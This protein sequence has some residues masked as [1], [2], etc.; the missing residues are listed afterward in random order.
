MP[1]IP[2]PSKEIPA[3]MYSAATTSPVDRG[4][5]GIDASSPLPSPL[6][7][8]GGGGSQAAASALS[9]P[10]SSVNTTPSA[11][12]VEVRD[13][14]QGGVNATTNVVMQSDS[15]RLTEGQGGLAKIVAP[16]SLEMSLHIPV[17]LEPSLRSAAVVEE[18]T[19]GLGLVKYHGISPE[20]SVLS[21][22]TSAPAAGS[23]CKYSCA[24]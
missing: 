16:T 10:T 8:N 3:S 20:L 15:A 11:E 23:A 2:P 13:Q 9:S 19:K 6:S 17:A 12:S 7:G 1:S 14:G 22:R 18:I 24:S 5:A 21:A 4:G